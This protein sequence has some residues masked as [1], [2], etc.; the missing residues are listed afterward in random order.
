MWLL[1]GAKEQDAQEGIFLPLPPQKFLVS[2]L[3]EISS[4]ILWYLVKN[5]KSF[6]CF[7]FLV[8]KNGH[9]SQAG[10]GGGRILV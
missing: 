1:F 2:I 10:G 3:V 4:Q 6:F 9:F 8:V 7:F 5:L